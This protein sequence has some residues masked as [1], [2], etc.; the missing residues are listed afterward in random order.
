[1]TDRAE[2]PA[3]NRNDQNQTSANENDLVRQL[4][5]RV[6]ELWQE[7]LRLER[8]RRGRLRR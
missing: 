3:P 5:E 2:A 8:E 4:A 7:E 6:W 1:M